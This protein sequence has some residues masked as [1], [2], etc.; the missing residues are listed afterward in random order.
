[1]RG[2]RILRCTVEER[3]SAMSLAWT[4]LSMACLSSEMS[5]KSGVRIWFVTSQSFI[6]ERG[7]DDLTRCLGR[8]LGRGLMIDPLVTDEVITAKNMQ[9]A[10]INN[11]E[12]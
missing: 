6:V 10:E 8:R 5:K 7:L 3:I 11:S 12:V 1:M 9:R 4:T 2:K